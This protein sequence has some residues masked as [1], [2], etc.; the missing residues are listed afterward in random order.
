MQ[1]DL[2]ALRNAGE[3]SRVVDYVRDEVADRMMERF[4]VRQYLDKPLTKTYN[5]SRI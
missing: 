1:K 2:S 5:D 3:P 4:M